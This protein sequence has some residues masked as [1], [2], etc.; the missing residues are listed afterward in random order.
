MKFALAALMATATQGINLNNALFDEEFVQATAEIA[1]REGSG[2][3]ARWVELPDCSIIKYSK[4]TA[5]DGTLIPLEADLSNAIIATC[6][7][8]NWTANSKTAFVQVADEVNPEDVTVLQITKPS[9]W[10]VEPPL[11]V[12]EAIVV[13]QVLVAHALGDGKVGHLCHIAENCIFSCRAQ[14]FEITKDGALHLANAPR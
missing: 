7:H 10:V 9:T 14:T 1:A 8:Y 12:F 3:R 2:V 13:G 6:K 5:G 11:L 4:A